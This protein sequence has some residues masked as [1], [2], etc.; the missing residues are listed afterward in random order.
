MVAVRSFLFFPCDYC[1]IL[2]SLYIAETARFIVVT[3]SLGGT[4]WDIFV[5]SAGNKLQ[6]T[7]G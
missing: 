3:N 4:G 6:G 7:M 1:V 5:L 2:V